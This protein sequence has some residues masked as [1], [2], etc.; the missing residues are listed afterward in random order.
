M[1]RIRLTVMVMVR[2]RVTVMVIVI[3][4]VTVMVMI[5]PGQVMIRVSNMIMSRSQS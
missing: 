5:S 1:V 3:I 4:K 2:I